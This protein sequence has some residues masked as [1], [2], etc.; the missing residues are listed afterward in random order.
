MGQDS[1]KSSEKG[2]WT[3]I[4]MTLDSPLRVIGL[5]LLV[6]D[7]VVGISGGV[8]TGLCARGNPWIIIAYFV[9]IIVILCF[10]I[11][12]LRKMIE[13]QPQ[14]FQQ[15]VKPDRRS[16]TVAEIKAIKAEEN[17]CS[18]VVNE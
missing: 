9:F 17:R 3:S 1:R 6:V 2:F 5:F 14:I 18:K 11:W 15:H 10:P 12:E 4:L 13:A 7:S 8:L 16:G